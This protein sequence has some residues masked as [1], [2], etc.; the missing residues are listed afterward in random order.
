MRPCGD[1]CTENA[2]CWP[3]DTF[4]GTAKCKC[5][6]GFSGNE[7][8]CR[9]RYKCKLI[10]LLI[11]NINNSRTIYFPSK[12]QFSHENIFIIIKN[13]TK[14]A[15]AAL[16]YVMLINDMHKGATCRKNTFT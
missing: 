7:T 6:V 5:K 4:D 14:D 13:Q 8:L 3:P 9:G 10:Y 2:T 11:I 12:T 1:G 16:E 15:R